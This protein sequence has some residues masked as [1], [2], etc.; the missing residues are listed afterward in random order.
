VLSIQKTKKRDF[1]MKRIWFVKMVL[2]GISV[3]FL[4]GSAARV[5]LAGEIHPVAPGEL[6]LHID[7][8]E[9]Q[10]V[11]AYV[12]GS[13]ITP[14]VSINQGS[15][16]A[17]ESVNILAFWHDANPLAVGDLFQLKYNFWEDNAHTQISDT[18]VA[19]FTGLDPLAGPANMQV[20]V[21]FYSDYH[22][23]LFPTI[24]TGPGV[25]DI[26]ELLDLR[27]GDANFQGLSDVSL[28]AT[29]VPE[30]SSLALLMV[31][32]IGFGIRAYRRR[33]TVVG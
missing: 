15:P 13:V 31:G 12:T 3:M 21:T 29:S 28:Y 8:E 2:L 33:R 26:G 24:L 1:T 5:V 6:H 14:V 23:T 25:Q 32:G 4:Q 11:A 22:E 20:Q 27:M 10:P 9:G 19:T 7:D 16:V 30:P 18:L 17:L